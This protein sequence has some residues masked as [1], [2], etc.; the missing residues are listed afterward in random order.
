VDACRRPTLPLCVCTICNG[1]FA[2]PSFQRTVTTAPKILNDAILRVGFELKLPMIDL[3]FVCSCTADFA[4][5]ID[6]SSMGEAKIARVI[7]NVV[8]GAKGDM[9]PARVF[10]DN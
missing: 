3:R 10:V 7:V 1:C 8:S 2:D 9:S 4:N 5:P 6:A